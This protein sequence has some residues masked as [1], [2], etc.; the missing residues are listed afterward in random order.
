LAEGSNAGLGKLARWN[1][2]WLDSALPGIHSN[3]TAS[4]TLTM[5]ATAASSPA[6]PNMEKSREQ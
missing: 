2:V 5:H 3:C 6:K 1:E 4:N